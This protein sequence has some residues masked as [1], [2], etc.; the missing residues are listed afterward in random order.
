MRHPCCVKTG[1]R[2]RYLRITQHGLG[3]THYL[4][5][6]IVKRTPGAFYRRVRREVGRDESP[7]QSIIHAEK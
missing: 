4:L 1:P 5:A 3:T 2:S 7:S 6:R